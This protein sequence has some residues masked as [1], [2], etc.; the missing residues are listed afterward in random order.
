MTYKN[1]KL[2]YEFGMF[3]LVILSLFTLPFD[4]EFV[5][6]LNLIIYFIFLTDYIVFFIKAPKK[7]RYIR[8]H[9]IELIALIPFDSMFRVFRGLRLLRLIRLSSVGSRYF[10]PIYS[11]LKEKNLH[12]VFIALLILLLIVP[13]PI[14]MLEPKINSYPDAFWWTIVTVTT[15]GYGDLSPVTLYGRCIAG[16]LM[17]IGISIIG[18]VTSV[19]STLFISSEKDISKIIAD[20]EKLS[21]EDKNKLRRYLN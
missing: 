10:T 9:L 4:N 13:I 17:I 2:W 11:F 14:F 16:I 5:R 7:L 1:Y 6:I 18:V 15:V 12:K 20:V 8:E 19:I 3:S 21:D